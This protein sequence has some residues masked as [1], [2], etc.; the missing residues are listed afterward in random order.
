M[1]FKRPST[2]L[3]KILIRKNEKTKK[4]LISLFTYLKYIFRI[5]KKKF[6][7]S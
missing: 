2:N 1:N 5:I 7:L 4:N 3:N 6:D